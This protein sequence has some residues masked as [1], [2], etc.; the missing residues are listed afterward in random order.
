MNR[1]AISLLFTYIV[2]CFFTQEHLM[3]RKL[4]TN[5]KLNNLLH[6]Y[7]LQLITKS[8]AVAVKLTPSRK[9]RENLRSQ[10]TSH[11]VALYHPFQYRHLC[12]CLRQYVHACY[13]NADH[14][15][16]VHSENH[17]EINCCSVKYKLS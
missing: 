13:V 3:T 15:N 4:M 2:T 10:R 16:D 14:R 8:N 5:I 6:L 7:Y 11:M 12:Y 1:C 17:L 9:C